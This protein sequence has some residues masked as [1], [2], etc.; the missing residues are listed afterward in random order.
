[1]AFLTDT[2]YLPVTAQMGEAITD[3]VSCSILVHWEAKRDSGES[4]TFSGQL[5]LFIFCC[6][7]VMDS[8]SCHTLV[9]YRTL[10]CDS[11]YCL[12]QQPNE[13]KSL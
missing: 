5:Y 7:E 13:N 3:K 2:P 4:S 9:V 1:M 8:L 12:K 11:S 10:A 6:I